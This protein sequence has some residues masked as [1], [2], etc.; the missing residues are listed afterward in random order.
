M[1]FRLPEG[2]RNA[3]DAYNKIE[4]RGGT[5]YP[6][7][8]QY[9]IGVNGCWHSGVHIH[10]NQTNN[11]VSPLVKGTIVA[12]RL[13][14]SF[15]AIP[16]LI[17]ITNEERESLSILEQFLY[18]R[19]NGGKTYTLKYRQFDDNK[20]NELEEEV[21][22][23]LGEAYKPGSI[24]NWFKEEGRVY[25]PI[26]KVSTEYVLLRHEVN[27][28]EH[29]VPGET[30][31]FFT[32]YMGIFTHITELKQYYEDF[33]E[34]R[35]SAPVIVR[36][37]VF[38]KWKFRLNYGRTPPIKRCKKYNT[39][40]VFEYSTCS[41]ELHDNDITQYNCTF[42][43]DKEKEGAKQ[44]GVDSIEPTSAQEY[45]TNKDRVQAFKIPQSGTIPS[46][47]TAIIR[48]NR[49]FLLVKPW[50]NNNDFYK[51]IVYNSDCHSYNSDLC[52]W[53]CN[54]TE[55]QKDTL[56]PLGSDQL[57][58]T[59]G[60]CREMP[61][62]HFFITREVYNNKARWW[63]VTIH[64]IVSWTW[65]QLIVIKKQASETR[66][67]FYYREREIEQMSVDDLYFHMLSN[68][69]INNTL[70]ERDITF[71]VLRIYEWKPVENFGPRDYADA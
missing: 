43:N 48:I 44:V 6:R 70:F 2:W 34:V 23:V 32:L 31:N 22:H 17:N 45:K 12:C 57:V 37:P 15:A 47:N 51:V 56:D 40:K 50:E 65:G 66:Y 39:F 1:L 41:F 30:I 61:S 4:A 52:G 8:G 38:Q 42:T 14:D 59:F 58:Y 64:D 68:K 67:S 71:N 26:E 19:N 3:E 33:H 35:A 54:M 11:S 9:P 49:N 5:E 60:Q 62:D 21:R 53:V 63:D 25:E 36:I 24:R 27:F 46:I 16:R 7:G 69:K 28:L 10:D 13:T 20:M 55:G 29:N 18:K